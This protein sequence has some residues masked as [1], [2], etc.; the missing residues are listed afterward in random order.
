VAALA[1]NWFTTEDHAE[2]DR[3]PLC[4]TRLSTLLATLDIEPSPGV[5]FQART[6]SFE[7]PDACLTTCFLACARAC[8]HKEHC[9]MDGSDD[10]VLLRPVGGPIAVEQS[11][12]K[13]HIAAGDA[14]LV[15]TSIPWTWDVSAVQRLDCLR[16][17]RSAVRS[18]P[19]DLLTTLPRRIGQ[20]VAA[21]QLLA[22]YGG[23][24]LQ[25]ILPVRSL[26]SRRIAACHVQDLLTMLLVTKE[27]D[28][29]VSVSNRLDLIKQDIDRHLPDRELSVEGIARHHKVTAR[30]VQ[31]LFEAEGT[32][33]S[34]HVLER[35]LN[36]AWERLRAEDGRADKISDIAY[37]VGF[38]DLSYFNRA[39]RRRFGMTPRHARLRT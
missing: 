19:A 24:L 7:L 11:G 4:R 13:V 10:I 20:D 28:N 17:P 8:R 33:F 18:A 38:G 29:T 31:K 1:P 21:F 9:L 15:S 36:A 34:E 5:P 32:T 2:K 23:A 16:V 25:G 26:E 12:R 39:F 37:E 6:L 14:V 27:Q 3:L 30:T 35:R 22:H